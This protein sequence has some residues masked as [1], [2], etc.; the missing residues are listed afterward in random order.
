[1]IET[2]ETVAFATKAKRGVTLSCQMLWLCVYYERRGEGKEKG[3]EE[4][5]REDEETRMKRG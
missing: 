2:A 4:R 5:E 3:E 1:M